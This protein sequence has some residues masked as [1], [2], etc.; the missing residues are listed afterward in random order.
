MPRQRSHQTKLVMHTL[1]DAPC[2]ETYGL[3][4]VKASGVSAGSAYAILR[5]LEDE[6]LLEARWEEVNEAEAGRP[7]RRYYR[8]NAL[9]RRVANQETAEEARALKMLSPGWGTG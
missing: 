1:L 5:R 6:G 2:D 4:V 9:G 7:P 8:L 3:E